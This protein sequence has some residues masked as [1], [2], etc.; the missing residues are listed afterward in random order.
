MPEVSTFKYIK[1]FSGTFLCIGKL[2]IC[3]CIIFF[4]FHACPVAKKRAQTDRQ[5]GGVTEGKRG[6]VNR[7][8]E[9]S[10]WDRQMPVWRQGIQYGGDL[11]WPRLREQMR[12]GMRRHSGRGHE[13]HEGATERQASAAGEDGVYSQKIFTSCSVKWPFI[14]IKSEV[15]TERQTKTGQFY[16]AHVELN[17]VCFAMS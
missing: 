10:H 17:K 1:R 8:R 4:Y 5:K 3:A 15:I 14:N 7:P 11:Q 12:P 2:L 13:R 16:L 9:H 6:S